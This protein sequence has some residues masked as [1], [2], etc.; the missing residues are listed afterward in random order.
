MSPLSPIQ[1]IDFGSRHRAASRA[2]HVPDFIPATRHRGIRRR[3]VLFTENFF[4]INNGSSR[5][6]S[7][8]TNQKTKRQ[9]KRVPARF[10]SRSPA[11]SLTKKLRHSNILPGLIKHGPQRPSS[12]FFPSH[13]RRPSKRTGSDDPVGTFVQR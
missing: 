10:R 6:K 2:I 8:S 4:N 13:H 1:T 5:Q 7:H 3:L 9:T 12:R 11:A